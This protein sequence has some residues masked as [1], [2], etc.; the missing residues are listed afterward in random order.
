MDILLTRIQYHDDQ[1]AFRQF[2]QTLY[3]RLHQF[4]YSYVHSKET[5]EELVND[6]FLSIWEKRNILHT[7]NNINVYL[8]VSVK[9]A[10]L[11][12]LRKKNLPIPLDTDDL[13]TDHIKLTINPET[14]TIGRDIHTQVQK[15]IEQLPPRC[16][17]IF[18]LVKEDGL[19]Y[20]EVASILDVSVKTVDAQLCVA[21]KKLA[22]ML[23]P[24]YP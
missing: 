10:S 3:L 9:N 4:A 18:K 23:Q 14:I 21:L 11:N 19:S 12:F 5:A 17:L 7:I 6:V 20:K 1:K 8:Y 22:G 13:H 15:A 16:K 2:Y 24:V